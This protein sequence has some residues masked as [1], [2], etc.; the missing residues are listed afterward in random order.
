MLQ[1]LTVVPDPPFLLADGDE[2]I[3]CLGALRRRRAGA[4]VDR[5]LFLLEDRDVR[6]VVP[7]PRLRGRAVQHRVVADEAA[8]SV[9]VADHVVR[10][11]P[12]CLGRDAGAQPPR[13][14]T[15]V[16]RVAR[17]GP[18]VIVEGRGQPAVRRL[19]PSEGLTFPVRAGH[20]AL[21]AVRDVREDRR[22]HRPV[23]QVI[24]INAVHS[25]LLAGGR[26][27]VSVRGGPVL[28]RAE[29]LAVDVDRVAVVD[30]HVD[31]AVLVGAG[32]A[33]GAVGHA[34]LRVPDPAARLPLLRK[35]RVSVLVGEV[36]VDVVH[37][38]ALPRGVAVDGHVVRLH[39]AA[40]PRRGVE[41]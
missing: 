19:L 25:G 36:H 12:V 14:D 7:V 35:V 31:L 34:Q 1:A 26:E 3:V 20:D 9:V 18:V 32:V 15:I 23:I 10:P 2:V 16:S 29:L 30:R 27:G 13:R 22:V 40:G 37:R 41:L 38:V 6:V 33:V 4:R 21:A 11:D 28:R 5:Q 17:R 39:P 24:T 8:I